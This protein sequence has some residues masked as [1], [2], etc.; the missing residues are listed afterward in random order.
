M[1]LLHELVD[2]EYRPVVVAPAGTLFVMREPFDF[3]VDPAQLID[4]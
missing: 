2:G 3:S 1:F 4:G